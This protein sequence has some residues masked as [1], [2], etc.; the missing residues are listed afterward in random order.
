MGDL[1]I[2]CEDCGWQ[3][4][5]I[6]LVSKTENQDDKD[7]KYCPDCGSDNIID[8]EEDDIEEYEERPL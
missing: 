6:E 1:E 3:G 8:I 4:Y 5:T 2:E 7:F